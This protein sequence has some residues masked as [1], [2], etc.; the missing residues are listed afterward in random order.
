MAQIGLFDES[1]RLEKLSKMGDILEKLNAVINWEMFRPI[2]TNAL[3]NTEK[4]CAGRP[5]YDFILLFKIIILQ[6]LYNLSDDATEYQINDRLSF[7]RFLGLD[8]SQTVPDAKTIWKFKNDLKNANVFKDIFDLFNEML[9]KEHII[10]HEGS[11]VDATFVEVPRQ[12]NTREENKTIKE[13]NIPEEWL[14][15]ENSHKLAQKDTD[16][17]WTKKNNETFF[18]YKNA[19]KVDA[20]SKIITDFVVTDAS[21]HDSQ[22]ILAL[23]DE[24]DKKLYAD[25]AYKSAAIDAS[26]PVT[27]ENNI[28]EKGYKNHPL[29]EEQKAFN[30]IKSKIRCRIEHVFGFITKSMNQITSRVIGKVANCFQIGITNL[31]YN[32]CRY[33]FL[34]RHLR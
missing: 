28:L 17:R 8:I 34:T 33:E 6:R 13:G 23:V 25:S 21:V 22:H 29:T 3:T 1:N 24:S 32:M 2:I 20:D 9:E 19:V 10:T 18:G 16:A 11:I 26:L 31:V 4:K 15:K 12:R 5:S 7:M 14:S 27:V 30:K